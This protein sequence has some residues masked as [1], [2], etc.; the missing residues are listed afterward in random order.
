MAPQTRSASKDAE[1]ISMQDKVPGAGRGIGSAAPHRLQW[2][3]RGRCGPAHRHQAA[4]C[5]GLQALAARQRGLHPP[6]ASRRRRHQWCR[7]AAAAAHP[8]RR[9]PPGLPHRLQVREAWLP[10][11]V[12]PWAEDGADAAGGDGPG[13]VGA[14]TAPV[15]VARAA[16]ASRAVCTAQN[17]GAACSTRVDCCIHIS[18]SATHPLPAAAVGH[19]TAAHGLCSF[20][21]PP[22]RLLTP[23]A[24]L[25]LAAAA[26]SWS[27]PTCGRMGRSRTCGAWRARRTSPSTWWVPPLFLSFL[28][29]KSTAGLTKPQFAE[30]PAWPL[31][32]HAGNAG[33]VG[34]VGQHGGR[35]ACCGW[36]GEWAE[37]SPHGAWLAWGRLGPPS[38]A[39]RWCA[40]RQPQ[41]RRPRPPAGAR[42]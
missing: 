32:C 26:R 28:F 37:G 15:R 6:A 27:W 11:A 1:A 7:R 40:P 16:A 20:W 42:R 35:L 3:C 33:P 25:L 14:A 21:Q 8:P 5:M 2:G 29:L 39:A 17:V 23:A 24:S 9:L 34:R 12:Q 18:I 13:E 4:R 10:C 41:Q 36:L 38:V 19:C 22:C 31:Y 30:F